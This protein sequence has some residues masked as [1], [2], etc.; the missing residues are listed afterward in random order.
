[1]RGFDCPQWPSVPY[2]IAAI[3]L[4]HAPC[5]SRRNCPA[6]YERFGD[7]L[8]NE[9]VD[10]FNQVDATYRGELRE[11]NELNFARFDA[12][13]EQRAAELDAKLEQR[14]AELDAKI[15]QRTAQLDAKIEQRT[16]QLDAKLEQ[17]IAEVKAE[18]HAGLAMLEGRLLARIG[19]LEGGLIGRIGMVEGRLTRLTVLLWVTLVATLLGVLR[20]T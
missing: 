5:P 15:E 14:T 11:L 1:M 10:W 12:K 7:E 6:C 19:V 8:T 2:R 9:L 3:D 16:A 13:L 4:E 20:L 18:L 17:R